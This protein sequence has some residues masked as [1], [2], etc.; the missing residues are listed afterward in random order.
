[1][2]E[3]KVFHDAIKDIP[4]MALKI[5]AEKKRIIGHYCSCRK[6]PAGILLLS[7]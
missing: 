6:S 5:K 2:Q 7:C 4:A 1:M 3:I